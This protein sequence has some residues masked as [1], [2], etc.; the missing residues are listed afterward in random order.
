MSTYVRSH[1]ASRT[2]VSIESNIRHMGSVHVDPSSD[3]FFT[4]RFWVLVPRCAGA[5]RKALCSLLDVVEASACLAASP[6][7]RGSRG[8]P[9][10]LHGPNDVE[11]ASYNGP[12]L[13]STRKEEEVDDLLRKQLTR[14]KGTKERK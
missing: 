4:T 9:Q 7:N 8:L 11:P 6:W 5:V 10:Q 13:I 2:L 1:I 3:A 12:L 14:K